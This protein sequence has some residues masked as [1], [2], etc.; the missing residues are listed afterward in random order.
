M[1][2]MINSMKS[3]VDYFFPIILQSNEIMH[4]NKKTT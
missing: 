2:K 3:Q 4:V 1:V